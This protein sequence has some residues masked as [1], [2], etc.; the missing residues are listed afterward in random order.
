VG[1]RLAVAAVPNRRRLNK[2]LSKD[3]V[4][5]L[6]DAWHHARR[7]GRPLNVLITLRPLRT[8]D[9]TPAE[10]CAIWQRLLNRLR[11][12]TQPPVQLASRALLEGGE[13][14]M[15]RSSDGASCGRA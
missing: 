9:L 10:R 7:I 11:V 1:R 8:D 15:R 14:G 5:D 2:G 4:V 13:S 12:G 6:W 3:E